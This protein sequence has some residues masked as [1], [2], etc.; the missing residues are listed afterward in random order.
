VE[1]E[2]VTLRETQSLFA[3]LVGKWVVWVYEQGWELTFGDF[4]RPDEHGHMANSNHY[5]RLAADVNLFVNGE[6]K[7]GDCIEWQKAGAYWESLNPLCRW[8]GRFHQVDLNH[9]AMEWQGRA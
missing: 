3:D 7:A 5:I 1:D 4:N 9:L 8:G 2:R 6:W